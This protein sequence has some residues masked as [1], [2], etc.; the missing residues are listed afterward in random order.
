M[1]TIEQCRRILGLEELSDEQV[2]T[3]RDNLYG[4][5]HML[6]DRYIRDHQLSVTNTPH[7]T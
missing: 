1:L 7:K 2:T 6:T 5:S 4:F 3:I